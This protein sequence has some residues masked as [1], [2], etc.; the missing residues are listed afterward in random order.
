MERVS[1][2]V[3]PDRPSKDIEALAPSPV[4]GADGSKG[5]WR[6]GNR[7][8]SSRVNALVSSH[9]SLYDRYGA[10]G[11][12]LNENTPVVRWGTAQHP[13]SRA[14]QEDHVSVQVLGD[15]RAGELPG[16]LALV[17]DGIGGFEAAEEASA[18]AVAGFT[19]AYRRRTPDEPPRDSLI[20]A[21]FSANDLLLLRARK[22]GIEGNFGSTLVVAAIDGPMLHWVSAGDSRAYLI[23]NDAVIQLT[24]D[25]VYADDLKYGAADGRIPPELA[26]SHP[27]RDLMT[28]YVGTEDLS[29]IDQNMHPYPLEDGD[30]LIL[31]SDGFYRNVSREEMLL[32]IDPDPQTAAERLV[33]LTVDR[34]IENQDNI[35]VVVLRISFPARTEEAVPP[36]DRRRLARKM[37]LGSAMLIFGALT[38]LALHLMSEQ[39]GPRRHA[40]SEGTP[41]APA[42]NEAPPAPQ[43]PAAP[44]EPP[45]AA[46]PA[47]Q[48]PAPEQAVAAPQ[49]T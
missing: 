21:L 13:G 45:A 8:Q 16:A 10:V 33:A 1:A 26:T 41:A 30:M 25:Q 31:C 47:A 4:S 29:H 22:R 24:R 44:A 7:R 23:R 6:A 27:D 5:P 15:P 28:S 38:A 19:D 12:A 39:S 48:P 43:A 40:Q 37:I 14:R 34:G 3:T 11:D 36:V 18:L 9:L 32:T 49:P 46:P 20:R 42:A 17:A 2:P 35:S